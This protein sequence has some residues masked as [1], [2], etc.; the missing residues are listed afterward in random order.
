MMNEDKENERFLGSKDNEGQELHLVHVA[1]NWHESNVPTE[2]EEAG[3]DARTVGVFPN[4]HS[5]AL[6]CAPALV[7]N[8]A[9][10]LGI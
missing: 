2:L 3:M 1:C 6:K 8:W 5:W 4:P 10:R 9:R 7:L